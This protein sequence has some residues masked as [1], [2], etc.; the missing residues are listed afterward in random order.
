M[1]TKAITHQV[2]EALAATLSCAATNCLTMA[3]L[4]KDAMC[5]D[6]ARAGRLAEA[7]GA[8]A[9]V[10]GYLIC[11]AQELTGSVG[12]A[13]AEGLFLPREAREVDRHIRESVREAAA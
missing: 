4:A 10:T 1:A 3:E 6:G 2:Q 12:T 8:M 5:S 7:I 9:S 11:H 13:S